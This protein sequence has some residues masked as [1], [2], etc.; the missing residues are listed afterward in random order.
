MPVKVGLLPLQ[1]ENQPGA[2]ELTSIMS[3]ALRPKV[4]VPQIARASLV[5]RGPLIVSP[6][7]KEI[8]SQYSPPELG[9]G[10]L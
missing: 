1:V 9:I 5:C 6:L 7:M 3:D 8:L 4:G 2:E 10:F